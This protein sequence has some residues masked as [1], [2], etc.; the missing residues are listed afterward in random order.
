MAS[1]YSSFVGK[2]Q[3]FERTCLLTIDTETTTLAII[4]STTIYGHRRSEFID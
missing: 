2:Y 4:E 1:D 3:N